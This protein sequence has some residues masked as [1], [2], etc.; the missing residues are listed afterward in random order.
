M[1]TFEKPSAEAEQKKGEDLY[2]RSMLNFEGYRDQARRQ[3]REAERQGDTQKIAECQRSIA[4]FGTIV[5]SLRAG[6]NGPAKQKYVSQIEANLN[7]IRSGIEN[8][9]GETH[10][11]RIMRIAS[12]LAELERGEMIKQ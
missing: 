1:S 11:E 8:E 7:L 12:E 4:E 10:A 9:P 5:E 3:L 2:P 6:E